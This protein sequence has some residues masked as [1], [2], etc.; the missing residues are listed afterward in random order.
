MNILVAVDSNWAIGYDGRLLVSLAED[1]KQF[2]KLTDKGVLIYGRKTLETFPGGKPL[3]GR[4]NIILS[5]D[6]T[7]AVSG[8]LVCR[9]LDELKTLCRKYQ[10]DEQWVIGGASIYEQL[11][12]WCQQAYVTQFDHSFTADV[13]FPD[14]DQ[15]ADWQL[16]ETGNWHTGVNRLSDD[17]NPL[18]FRFVRYDKKDQH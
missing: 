11:L 17:E 16:A 1:M 3:P 15:L 9:H 14:L 12:P 8:A 7:F 6:P 5:R 18:R 4:T 13:Y 10:S 2:R